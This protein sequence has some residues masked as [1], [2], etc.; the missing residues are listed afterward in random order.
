MAFGALGRHWAMWRAAWQAESNRPGGSTGSTGQ[1]TEFLPAVLEI[2][3]I[4]PSPVGR[5]LL[6]TILAAFTAAGLWATFGWI[7]I[8][9]TAQGKIIPSGYSKIIQPYEAAVIASIQVQDGQVVRQGDVLI[10]AMS[11]TRGKFLVRLGMEGE[12]VVE[13]EHLLVEN[14]RRVRAVAQGADGAVY[15]L[16]DSEDNDQTNRHFPGEVIRLTPR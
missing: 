14:D 9:A 10:G 4:P 13:E 15:V 11:P 12:K 7:D 6:W 8:V 1:A 16:T 3:Q 5:A 2:Q